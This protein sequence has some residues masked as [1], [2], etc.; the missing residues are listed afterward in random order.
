MKD[1]LPQSE[2][3]LTF[4]L[5]FRYIKHLIISFSIR[6]LIG[7][8]ALCGLEIDS[9]AT[10]CVNLCQVGYEQHSTL[11]PDDWTLL[12]PNTPHFGLIMCLIMSVV[13]N[14]Q[15]RKY[16]IINSSSFFTVCI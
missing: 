12:K 4:I 9:L 7:I 13:Q 16:F 6:Y 2:L 5:L 14:D 15:T 8:C 1:Q 3:I 10:K 11:K